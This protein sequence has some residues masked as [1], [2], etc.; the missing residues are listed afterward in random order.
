M[1]NLGLTLELWMRILVNFSNDCRIHPDDSGL[2]GAHIFLGMG[3]GEEDGW[4]KNGTFE[5]DV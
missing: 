3:I 1:M 2:N 5:G 4:G